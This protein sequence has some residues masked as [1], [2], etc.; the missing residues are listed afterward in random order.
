MWQGLVPTLLWMRGEVRLGVT[1]T[2]AGG[3]L[4][5][6]WAGVWRAGV[7]A[8]YSWLPPPEGGRDKQAGT[9]LGFR[10]STFSPLARGVWHH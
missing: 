2:V 9:F 10:T 6:G 4:E 5:E 1:D 7:P 3:E 8:S